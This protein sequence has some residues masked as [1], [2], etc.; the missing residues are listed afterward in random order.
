MT[1]DYE[2]DTSYSITITATDS[3]SNTVAKDFTISVTDVN[4]APSITS[5]NTTSLAENTSSILTVAS[6]DPDHGHGR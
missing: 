4:E 3:A 5:S 6:N 2:S 1:A